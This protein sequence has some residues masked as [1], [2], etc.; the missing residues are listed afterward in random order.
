ME[1]INWTSIGVL[2]VLVV[3][4]LY[5]FV[6]TAPSKPPET[7]KVHNVPLPPPPPPVC[8]CVFDID[9]TLTCG[10]PAGV[11]QM[12]KDYGCVC[13]LNTARNRPYAGDVPL[14]RQGFPTNVLNGE[15]F[16]YN[17]KPTYEN[18]VPTK[19]A[20]LQYFQYKWKIE[21]PSKILFFDDSLSNI[22]GANAAGFK[23]VWCPTTEQQ[24]GV[25]ADQEEMAAEFFRQNL[26]EGALRK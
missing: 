17:P 8:G 3:I 12:C 20:G 10:D 25:G 2:I 9:K 1:K 26:G 6:E 23:G 24:C 18:V 11:V 21:S 4:F 16:I 15:D 7:L 14:K 22:E 13:G 5:V 19:V